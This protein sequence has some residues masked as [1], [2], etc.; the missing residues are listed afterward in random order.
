MRRGGR[1]G[2]ARFD[3]EIDDLYL[4]I[5]GDWDEHQHQQHKDSFSC[6]GC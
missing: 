5:N 6:D 4:M 2:K 1:V 3:E